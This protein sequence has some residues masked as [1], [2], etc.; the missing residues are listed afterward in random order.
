MADF[1]GYFPGEEDLRG[2]VVRSI[3]G[4]FPSVLVDEEHFSGP[5]LS[6]TIDFPGTLLTQDRG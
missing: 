6:I 5:F 2:P 3:P 1:N 4:D